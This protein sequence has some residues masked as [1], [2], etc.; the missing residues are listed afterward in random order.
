METVRGHE[1][2]RDEILL[3]LLKEEEGA[4]AVSAEP[5]VVNLTEGFNLMLCEAQLVQ[6]GSNRS[7]Y[8][9]KAGIFRHL[10]DFDR[11]FFG[12][13]A[14]LRKFPVGEITIDEGFENLFCFRK[15]VLAIASR[16]D[17]SLTAF[18]DAEGLV[19]ARLPD[20][21]RLLFNERL[22]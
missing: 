17:E 20:L 9:H 1:D 22:Q 18:D 8:L 3:I 4:V 2:A 5:L 7:E 19:F 13:M 14:C 12:W 15:E 10:V 6:I 11:N 16:N 21:G